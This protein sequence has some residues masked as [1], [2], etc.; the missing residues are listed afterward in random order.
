MFWKK[1]VMWYKGAVIGLIIGFIVSIG[2]AKES[3]IWNILA[4]PGLITCRTIT[5]CPQCIQC[6]VIALVFNLIYGFVIGAF[7]GWL[8]DKSNKKE[9]KEK[10]KRRKKR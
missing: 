7:I 3:G 10:S 9:V 5:Q 6:T 2:L 4:S 1:W 8:I